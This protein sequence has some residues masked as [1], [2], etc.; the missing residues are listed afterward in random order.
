MKILIIY[1]HPWEG[2][3]SH[4]L[5]DSVIEGLNT[6]NIHYKIIDLYKDDFNPVFKKEELALYNKG[7]FIDKKVAD[8]QKMINNSDH[9]F[10]IF[11]IW[12]GMVPAMLKGFIDKVFLKKWAYDLNGLKTVKKLT[13]IKK[14]TIITTL[15]SPRI[16]Y[17]IFIQWVIKIFFGINL[18][19]LCGIKK[20]KYFV[21][22]SIKGINNKKRIDFLKKVKNYCK[23]L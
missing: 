11:P 1:S 2:S 12:W 18:L 16:Y 15:N 7:E 5:L 13:F 8:Y 22:P 23:N 10:F 20:I 14:T 3:F 19:K 9:I 21:R 17:L 6:K 4:A